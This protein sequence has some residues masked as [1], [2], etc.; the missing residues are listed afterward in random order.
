MRV[1]LSFGRSVHEFKAA[2]AARHPHVLA[3]YADPSI[4]RGVMRHHLSTPDMI[5]Q[6]HLIIDS[7]A[8]TAFTQGQRIDIHAYGEFLTNFQA[9][10][11]DALASLEVMNLDVIGDQDASARNEQVLRDEYGL[12]PTPVFTFGAPV[13]ELRDMAARSP[14]LALGGLVPYSQDRDT[15]HGWLR[16]CFDALQGQSVSVHLLGIAQEDVLRAFPAATCDSTAWSNVVRAGRARH[17]EAIHPGN[18]WKI[19]A[20]TERVEQVQRMEHRVTDYWQTAKY[21]PAPAPLLESA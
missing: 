3:S 14:R 12:T 16:R 21:T 15:L 2:R 13:Q 9:V 5:G 1:H 6:G 7:G 19:P 4:I 20:L 18:T 8:F 17:L 11:G 10:H